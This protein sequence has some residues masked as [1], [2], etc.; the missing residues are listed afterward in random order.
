LTQAPVITARAD[1][2]P[3]NP[4]LRNFAD[5][6]IGA[7]VNGP[8]LIRTRPWMQ[9]RLGAYYLYFAHHV[10]SYIRLAY[11]DDLTGPWHIHEPGALSIDQMPWVYEHCA[12]P[13]VHVDDDAQEIR[14]YVHAISDP[15]PWEEPRQSS[16]LASSR[17]GINFAPNPEELGPSYF[18]VWRSGADYFALSLGGAL[19]RSHDG[20]SAFTPGPRLKG[21]PPGTRH[22]A[23]LQRGG[24]VWTAWSVIG[25]CPERIMIGAFDPSGDWNTWAMMHVQELLRPEHAWEG[26]AL[27]LRPSAVG[28]SQA[29]AHQLRDPCFFT[30]AGRDYLLYS[31]A[32]EA[33]IA[34]A[35][36]TLIGDPS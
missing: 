3:G 10:G 28:L 30:D 4:I 31:V 34:I 26:A 9:N 23:V 20:C 15:A 12:S 1:R 27:P 16:Y 13:D 6:R 25:D 11:A 5:R 17:D 32:G 22:L 8:S 19:W 2:L 7:N 35:A 14:M 36:F 33:G 21:L 24:L 18:R 29:P